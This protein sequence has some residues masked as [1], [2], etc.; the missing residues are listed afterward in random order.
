MRVNGRTIQTLEI[1]DRKKRDYEFAIPAEVIGEDGVVDVTIHYLTPMRQSEIGVS[2]DSR[3]QGIAVETI[4]IDRK[5][6][7]N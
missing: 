6:A 4:S 1:K 7:D 3:L 5:K 2:G